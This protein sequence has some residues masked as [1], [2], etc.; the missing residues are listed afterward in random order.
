MTLLWYRNIPT[1]HTDFNRVFQIDPFFRRFLHTS[2]LTCRNI[3]SRIGKHVRH[4]RMARSWLGWLF[5]VLTAFVLFYIYLS[6]NGN[7]NVT[8][9]LSPSTENIGTLLLVPSGEERGSKVGKKWRSWSVG[10]ERSEQRTEG[11]F[12]EGSQLGNNFEV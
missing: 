9:D 3:I 7:C 11:R 10:T 5:I 6:L 12:L 8:I 2:N 1:L 4:I